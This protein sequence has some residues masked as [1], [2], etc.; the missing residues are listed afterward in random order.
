MDCIKG[1]PVRPRQ[2]WDGTDGTRKSK[3]EKITP[4]P[5]GRHVLSFPF[6]FLL[7]PCLSALLQAEAFARAAESDRFSLKQI[8]A[9]IGVP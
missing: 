4:A 9:R 5:N 1:I 6:Y 7:L 8:R 3:K 2:I